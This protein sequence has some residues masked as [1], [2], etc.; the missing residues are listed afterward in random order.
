MFGVCYND[1]IHP[2]TF[3][4]VS[5]VIVSI[6]TKRFKSDCTVNTAEVVCDYITFIFFIIMR[7]KHM[8][9]KKFLFDCAV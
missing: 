7:Y 2:C 9:W 3:F 8:Y 4:V 6:E 1:I 5:L